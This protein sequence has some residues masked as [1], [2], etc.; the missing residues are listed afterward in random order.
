[1]ALISSKLW[2]ESGQLF[3]ECPG[4][5][6]PHSVNIDKTKR[7]PCWEFNH[8]LVYPTFS[9]SILVRWSYGDPPKNRVC[10]SFVR[11]GNIQFLSD[12]THDLAGQTV[13]IPLWDNNW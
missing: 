3:F 12:C 7:G 2:A 13:E 5:K 1:M 9:P 4:C 6:M 10:H 11:D 8:N